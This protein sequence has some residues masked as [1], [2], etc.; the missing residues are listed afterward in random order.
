MHYAVNSTA[1]VNKV[2]AEGTA[3]SLASKQPH[4]DVNSRSEPLLHTVLLQGL[5]YSNK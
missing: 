4:S 1:F 2:G 3:D 5:D